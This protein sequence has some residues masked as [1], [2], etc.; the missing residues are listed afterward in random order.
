MWCQKLEKLEMSD[1]LQKKKKKKIHELIL[2]I[3][4]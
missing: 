1:I 2:K 3:T 4:N